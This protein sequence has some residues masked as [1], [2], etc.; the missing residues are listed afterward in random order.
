[1]KNYLVYCNKITSYYWKLLKWQDLYKR[2]DNENGRNYGCGQ[3]DIQRR[4]TV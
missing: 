1:M 3:I 4:R 2:K